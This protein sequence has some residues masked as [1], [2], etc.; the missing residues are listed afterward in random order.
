MI[1]IKLLLIAMLPL[2]VNAQNWGTVSILNPSFA[3]DNR[4]NATLDLSGNENLTPDVPEWTQDLIM[5]MLRVD[6][7]GEEPTINSTREK[8]WILEKL[9]ITGVHITP[10]AESF[11]YNDKPEEWGFYSFTEPNKLEPQLET[12]ADFKALVDELHAMGIKVFLDFEFHGVFDRDVFI[13]KL[14]W[15]SAWDAAGPENTSSLLTSHPEFFKWID[16]EFGHHPQYTGWNTAELIWKKDDGS[17]N[18]SLKDWYRD[19]LVNDWIVKYDLDGLRLDLEPFEIANVIGYSYWQSL[20]DLAKEKTGTI[21]RQI[22]HS[23][24]RSVR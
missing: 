19:V 20:I 23:S 7:F 1:K 12:E 22:R 9:G 5:Y 8:L 24:M 18:Q 10:V 17:H 2:I 6:K 15:Q 11:I 14:N 13:K 21:L 3:N 16:D 4:F